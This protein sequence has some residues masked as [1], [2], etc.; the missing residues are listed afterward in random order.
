[1]LQQD[2]AA[3]MGITR[4]RVQQI[5]KKYNAVPPAPSRRRRAMI[6]LPCRFCG[7]MVERHT[8]EA[9]RLKRG[10]NCPNCIGWMEVTCPVCDKPRLVRRGMRRKAVKRHLEVPI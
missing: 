6:E 2:V 1:V 3:E 9:A 10:P 8:W 4:Q 5:A 7:T